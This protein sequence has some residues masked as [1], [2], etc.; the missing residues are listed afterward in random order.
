MFMSQ[1]HVPFKIVYLTEISFLKNMMK[2]ENDKANI[3][4]HL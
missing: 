4:L 1:K 3:A 2:E